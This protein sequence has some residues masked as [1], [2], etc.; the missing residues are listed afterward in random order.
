MRRGGLGA[1]DGH[2]S[3]GE[4]ADGGRGSCEGYDGGES[5]E[6]DDNGGYGVGNS[7]IDSRLTG[8]GETVGRGLVSALVVFLGEIA[9]DAVEAQLGCVGRG[10]E[11]TVVVLLLLEGGRLLLYELGG[12]TG[13]A[14]SG[15]GSRDGRG[16]REER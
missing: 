9:C 4:G 12:F 1:S 16:E 6:D 7:L 3:H 5:R 14:G 13:G 8:E 2:E 15:D 10:D 11:R